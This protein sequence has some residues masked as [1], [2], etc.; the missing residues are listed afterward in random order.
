MTVSGEENAPT[1]LEPVGSFDHECHSTTEQSYLP[2]SLIQKT[3][4]ES[5]YDFDSGE[6]SGWVQSLEMA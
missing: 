2:D 4:V 3:F 5:A 6:I 1:G